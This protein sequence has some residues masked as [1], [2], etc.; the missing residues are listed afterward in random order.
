MKNKSLEKK[1]ISNIQYKMN[2]NISPLDEGIAQ[3]KS[4][5]G[6]KPKPL[7]ESKL[8]KIEDKI[9]RNDI[10]NEIL[11]L[12][13]KLYKENKITKSLHN[14][15]FDISIGSARM[16][17]LQNAYESL[18]E[19]GNNEELV[20]KHQYNTLLKQKKQ[21]YRERKLNKEEVIDSKTYQFK[22]Q[23][24]PNDVARVFNNF[25]TALDF[26]LPRNHDYSKWSDNTRKTTHNFMYNG[27]VGELDTLLYQVFNQQKIQ[28]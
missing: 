7:T 19:V 3:P 14:K 9:K 12:S 28:I 17:T 25:Y 2:N 1:L 22:F 15:M 23:P 26:V 10:K 8:M 5:R 13:R 27:A 16:D 20:K 11:K 6:R 4:K 21:E 18:I 24:K